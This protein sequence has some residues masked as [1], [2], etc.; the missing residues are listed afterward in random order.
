VTP[1]E[2]YVDR[3]TESLPGAARMGNL[4][5]RARWIGFGTPDDAILAYSRQRY[6]SSFLGD[7]AVVLRLDGTV[8][9]MRLEEFEPLLKKQQ[10]AD[11]IKMLKEHVK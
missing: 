9:W 10:K 4:E 1:P 3:I 8:E 11:E 7:G 2:S 6:R 5:Y